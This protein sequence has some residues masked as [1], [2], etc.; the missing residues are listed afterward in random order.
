MERAPVD[1]GTIDKERETAVKEDGFDSVLKGRTHPLC[2]I[3]RA[4]RD[5]GD[6]TA[7]INVEVEADA[8]PEEYVSSVIGSIWTLT[9]NEPSTD[10]TLVYAQRLAL[11]ETKLGKVMIRLSVITSDIVPSA[12]YGH[13]GKPTIIEIALSANHPRHGLAMERS[14]RTA[15]LKRCCIACAEPAFE[16]WLVERVKAIGLAPI[17]Q[18]ESR[19]NNPDHPAI[20]TEDRCAEM[21]VRLARIH[22][23]SDIVASA[24]AAEAADR[25]IR[26]YRST[27]WRAS[28]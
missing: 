7:I 15:V 19:A 9:I 18:P 3:R 16:T 17:G 5:G 6:G 10:P 4:T 25:I 2:G 13:S 11:T 24:A 20:T 8:L 23:R 14:E 12:L 21:L 26:A 1:A 28:R 22:S 27:L